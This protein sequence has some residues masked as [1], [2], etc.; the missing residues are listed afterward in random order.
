MLCSLY[1]YL[2]LIKN[3]LFPSSSPLYLSLQIVLLLKI[4]VRF[5]EII[6]LY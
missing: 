3:Y 6:D 5:C 1:V 4:Q 2:I